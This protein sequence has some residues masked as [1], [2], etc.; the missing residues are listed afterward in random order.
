MNNNVS[1]DAMLQMA[2]RESVYRQLDSFPS[3]RELEDMFTPSDTHENKIKKII[4]K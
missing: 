3:K 1:F 4:K 2:A